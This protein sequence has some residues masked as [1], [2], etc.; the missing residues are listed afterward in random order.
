MKLLSD[1]TFYDSWQLR[2]LNLTA[3]H[4]YRVLHDA[5]DLR[6]GDIVQFAGF[7]DVDNHFGIFVFLDANGQVREVAGDC[8]GPQH[9][10]MRELKLALAPHCLA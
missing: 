6:Q 2:E 7:D 5:G 4:H 10:C 1:Y 9:S 3:G 8:A